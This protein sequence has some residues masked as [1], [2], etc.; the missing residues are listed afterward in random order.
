MT[1]CLHLKQTTPRRDEQ[2]EYCR[3]LE[4]GARLPWAW[5]VDDRWQ[6]RAHP[7]E[8]AWKTLVDSLSVI[9]R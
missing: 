4:C 1:W 6:D 8:S 3:C 7:A 2:G 9:H 5:E